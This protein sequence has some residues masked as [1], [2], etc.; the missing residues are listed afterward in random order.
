MVKKRFTYSI[1]LIF[2][3]VYS[4]NICKSQT[5]WQPQKYNGVNPSSKSALFTDHFDDNSHKWEL[6]SDKGIQ[7]KL[8]D[9]FLILE[10]ESKK[11]S[12]NAKIKLNENENFE[13]E[14]TLKFLSGNPKRAFGL[15]WGKSK[16]GDRYFS[17]VINANRQFAISKYSGAYI[18]YKQEA[19]SSLV[20]TNDFNKL[21]IRKVDNMIYFFLN[22]ALVYSREY[23]LAYGNFIGFQSAGGNSVQADYLKIKKL[24]FKKE[25]KPP[26]IFLIEPETNN[27][28]IELN[29]QQKTIRIKGFVKDEQRINIIKIN[30][31]E[32]PLQNDG[33]FNTE[34][35]VENNLKSIKLSVTDN[36][37][38]T[39]VEYINIRRLKN[40]QNNQNQQK[41]EIKGE[42]YA[43][44][45][46]VNEYESDDVPDL[47]GPLT[48]AERLKEILIGYYT[49]ESENVKLLENPDRVDFIVALDEISNNIGKEDNL[50]IFYA[51]HGY[52]NFKK[53][54]GYW[55]PADASMS[56][57]ANWFRNSTLKSYIASINTRNILLISDACF[58]GG[59]FKS[60][61]ISLMAPGK[62]AELYNLPSRKAMTSG[63]L[64]EV[65]DESQFLK[66]MT[67]R[68]IDNKEKFISS[69]DLFK[70]F[71]QAVMNNTI[72]D[73][74]FG[75]IRNSG[76]QG[77]DF[78]FIR[79]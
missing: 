78:I 37:L 45:I 33:S 36:Q 16:S 4:I 49:F 39:S 44:I 40:D 79:K 72:N 59:I 52:W 60:R 1:L 25:N 5:V 6:Q 17:F 11:V 8:D 56:N 10:S 7:V 15:Q 26:D 21:T 55:L 74:Q 54:L 19:E 58:A 20:K 13:I 73:P 57:T 61:G 38:Q 48:D 14:T 70:S 50:L 23:K 67:K 31:T 18:S 28:F 22:E 41:T 3:F 71:K 34:I 65:P 9:G 46:A 66:Y 32:F 75:T 76:D 77:G 43:L 69:E 68:L 63:N 12:S 42:Y 51:G 53:K 24:N 30:K 62:I 2:L 64:K 47:S 35:N 27:T 29:A